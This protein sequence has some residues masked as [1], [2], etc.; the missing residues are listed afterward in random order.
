MHNT[1]RVS[2]DGLAGGFTRRRR[3]H[4]RCRKSDPTCAV[5]PGARVVLREVATGREVVVQA[6]AEGRYQ[7]ESRLSAP[8][9]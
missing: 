3:H 6:G 8:T 9:S 2:S 1:C 4:H 5:L 7:V